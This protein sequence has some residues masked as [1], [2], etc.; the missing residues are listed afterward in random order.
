MDIG[1]IMQMLRGWEH[2][3]LMIRLEVRKLAQQ[4]ADAARWHKTAMLD[5]LMWISECDRE[6]FDVC[7][8]ELRAALKE[9][10]NEHNTREIPAGVKAS[11]ANGVLLAS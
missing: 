7:K 11:P 4:A 2:Q 9:V 6:G 3:P 5:R 1:E 10:C 8:R